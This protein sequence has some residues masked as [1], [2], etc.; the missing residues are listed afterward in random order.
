VYITAI[1]YSGLEKRYKAESSTYLIFLFLVLQLWFLALLNEMRELVK[2]A[3]FCS[4]FPEAGEDGGVE[5]GKN[6]DGDETF[7]I[8]G[9]TKQDRMICGGCVALRVIVVIYLGV[10][11]SIFLIMETGY[12]DLLMNA[13]ALAFILEIDEILFGAVAR[14]TTCDELA[15]CEDLEFETRLPTEGCAGWMLH[16]DFWGIVAFPLI[17][18]TIMIFNSMLS[19]KPILDALNCACNQTGSQCHEASFYN[20]EWW[21]NYWSS[22]LPSAMTQIAVLKAKAGL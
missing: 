18:I 19:N 20:Q 14:A 13:V 16:K 22:T 11:G 1:D 8:T 17:A 3:E 5:V 9:L 7:T 4:V 21:N 6:E 15:A 10:V 12:M 2:L